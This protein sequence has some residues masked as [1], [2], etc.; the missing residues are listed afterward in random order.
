VNEAI[1]SYCKNEVS[2]D[3]DYCPRCGTL[4]AESAKCILHNEIN[5]EG[6]CV[7]CSEPFCSECGGY[8]N[9]VFLCN[10]HNS[11]E[12]YEGFARIFGSSD[13]TQ[14]DYVKS[15][16]EQSLLHPIILSNKFS[17]MY[18]GSEAYSMFKAGE[19]SN[20]YIYNE[21]KVLVPCSEVT[22]AEKIITELEL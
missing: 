6:V 1:C 21:F 18:L 10:E 12:I 22:E 11:Y 16:L 14:C 7:I 2:E 13:S 17:Q 4:F 15:C 9:K 20:I 5:A 3:S 8:V 19:D